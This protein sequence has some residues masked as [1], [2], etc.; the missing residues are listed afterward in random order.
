MCYD[1]VHGGEVFAA[2]LPRG[3]L[4]GVYPQTLHL[5][6]D[7]LPHVAEEGA[8]HV[9]GMMGHPHVRVQ[10]LV[11]VGLRVVGRVVVRSGVQHLVMGR[12]VRVV[13]GR[14]FGVM[15]E[16]DGIAGSRLGRRELVVVPTEEEVPRG[17][18]GVVV[19]MAHVPVVGLEVVV[20]RSGAHFRGGHRR[21]RILVRRR[22]GGASA[23]V[24][25]A[26]LQ[27]VRGQMMVAGVHERVDHLPSLDVANKKSTKTNTG[28]NVNT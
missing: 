21:R 26:H 15:V 20:L 14:H 22:Y 27:A 10:V 7:G 25:R 9:G 19:Q 4:V 28:R 2:R 6:L 1:F 13:M 3:R 11:V 24:A 12:Q 8:V 5:L 16:Q 23:V 17:V 18:A